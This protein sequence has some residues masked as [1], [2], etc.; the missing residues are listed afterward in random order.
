LRIPSYLSCGPFHVRLEFQ[1]IS[2]H[3]AEFDEG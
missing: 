3:V 1:V 2:G